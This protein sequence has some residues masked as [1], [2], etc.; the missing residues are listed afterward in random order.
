[1]SQFKTASELHRAWAAWL[2]MCEGTEA[3]VNRGWR[4]VSRGYSNYTPHFDG[5]P[6]YYEIAI[7]IVENR[8]VFVGDKLYHISGIQCTII[9]GMDYDFT[10]LSWSP[11]PKTAVVELPVEGIGYILTNIAKTFEDELIAL[12]E[13]EL[14]QRW[15]FKWDEKASIEW[16]TYK[17]SDMLEMY[18]RSCRR[19]EENHNGS[20]CVVERV[21]DKYLMPKV[22]EFLADLAGHN[23]KVGKL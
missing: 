22:R 7:G 1:M 15:Y 21:R 6:T 3:D 12:T 18:K 10:L 5:K 17:F 9:A 14:E 8:P 2:E 11:K 20:C 19:W 4:W 16:N 23:V 13:R